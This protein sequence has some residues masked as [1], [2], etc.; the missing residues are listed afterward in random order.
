MH[1]M[2]EIA[3][4]FNVDMILVESDNGSDYKSCQHFHQI[5]KSCD[6][7]GIPILRVYGTPEHCKHEVN[8]V[9][10]VAKSFFRRSIAAGQFFAD[11]PEM[12]IYRRNLLRR[13]TQNMLLRS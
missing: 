6:V 3:A 12:I 4:E 10:G 7:I 5:Q 11:V 1:K 8:H 2:F 13:N 9:G